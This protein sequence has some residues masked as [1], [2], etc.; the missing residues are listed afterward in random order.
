MRAQ[1][2]RRRWLALLS[3]G[4]LVAA[5]LMT[6]TAAGAAV[7]CDTPRIYPLDKVHRGLSA[8]AWTAVRGTT[9]KPFQVRVLGVQRDAIA[10]GFDLIV[11]KV[12]GDLIRRTGGIAAGFS[13][14][15]AY[16]HGALVGSVSWSIDGAPRYGALTPAGYLLSILKTHMRDVRTPDRIALDPGLASLVAGRSGVRTSA[17]LQQI[18]LPLA[19]SGASGAAMDR[20]QQHFADRGVSVLPYSAGAASASTTVD[21]TM[22]KAGQPV[23]AAISFGAISYAAVGTVTFTCGNSMVA[24]GHYYQHAGAARSAAM[25]RANVIATVKDL[26][27]PFK[28]ANLGGLAGTIEQDRYAGILGVHRTQVSATTISSRIES[29]DTGRTRNAVTRVMSPGELPWIA[30]EHLYYALRMGLDTFAG[31]VD[32]RWTISGHTGDRRFSVTLRTMRS[33]SVYRPADDVYSSI[34]SIQDAGGRIDAVHAAATVTQ[35]RKVATFGLTKTASTTEPTL[36]GRG[37]IDVAA[38]DTLDVRIPLLRKD[39][40]VDAVE[41]TFTIGAGVTDDGELDVWRANPVYSA[42][43]TLAEVLRTLS[44]QS[45]SNVAFVRVRMPGSDTQVHRIRVD[46]VLKGTAHA[47]VLHLI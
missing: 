24:F 11:V 6:S 32:M 7:Q 4:A 30:F 25:L 18:P 22:P 16:H 35:A 19:V 2:V 3:V 13:G 1:P 33:G 36:A 45:S 14:S 15:P 47:V 42:R 26:W 37:S 31:T 34:R 8:T 44:H 9:P 27:G 12:S 43:G 23:A 38:G 17:M 40:V 39:E 28:L 46:H 10:P 20:I 21:A 41:T 29:R 5:S